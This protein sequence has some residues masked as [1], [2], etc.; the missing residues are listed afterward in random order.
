MDCPASRLMQNKPISAQKI[1]INVL[2]ATAPCYGH[3]IYYCQFI[4]QL[5]SNAPV[6]V[7]D[8]VQIARAPEKRNKNDNFHAWSC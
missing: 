5:C 3:Q 6:A 1:K 2:K 4:A 7:S 8:S